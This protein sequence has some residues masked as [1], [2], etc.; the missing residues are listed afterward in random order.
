MTA[1]DSGDFARAQAVVG[2]T[3]VS[4]QRGGM[5]GNYSDY[6]QFV[7]VSSR[8]LGSD[9]DVFRR[10]FHTRGENGDLL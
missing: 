2:H 7:M 6:K 5:A 9:E 8:F 1:N 3:W 4:G 10:E